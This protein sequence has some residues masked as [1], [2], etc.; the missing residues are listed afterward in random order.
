M[1]RTQLIG[2][3][4]SPNARDAYGRT[5]LMRVVMPAVWRA[6][7]KECVILLLHRGADTNLSDYFGKTALHYLAS[8]PLVYLKQKG[9]GAVFDLRE[10]ERWRIEVA[11]VLIT[12]G[13]DPRR[14]DM[15]GETAADIAK[16][17]GAV[18]LAKFLQ[19]KGSKKR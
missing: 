14:K 16:S 15:L 8:F 3:G 4:N 1:C 9:G 13:A 12:A 6:T 19:G 10:Q 7:A 18:Q 17:Q 11:R 5:P 2:A